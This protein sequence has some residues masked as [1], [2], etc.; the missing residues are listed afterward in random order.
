MSNT[1]KPFLPS[2]P[3][4]YQLSARVILTARPFVGRATKSQTA[5]VIENK[6]PALCM[7]DSNSSAWH[8]SAQ[9]R[10]TEMKYSRLLHRNLAFCGDVE[11]PIR[12]KK[13]IPQ[14]HPSRREI[15]ISCNLTALYGHGTYAANSFF[16]YVAH[17]A[18]SNW[19]SPRVHSLY[20]NFVRLM[21]RENYY[22]IFCNDEMSFILI[23]TRKSSKHS[24][25]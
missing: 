13:S 10:V 18:L 7:C 12:N 9:T 24:Y 11:N 5:D 19:I 16:A 8:S 20:K 14:R 17:A 15:Q 25:F 2:I 6:S 23:F 1:Q 3:T 4:K 22:S 21:V